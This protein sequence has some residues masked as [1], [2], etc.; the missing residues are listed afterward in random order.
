M[1]P[2]LMSASLPSGLARRLTA[3]QFV[4]TAEVVP[5]VSCDPAD[6]L[7]QALP[8]RGLERVSEVKFAD[9]K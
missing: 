5:P 6:L 1:Q 4:L 3:G 2:D 9:P 7:A 8:L